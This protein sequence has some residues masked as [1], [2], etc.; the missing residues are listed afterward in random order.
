M[1]FLSDP[2]LGQEQIIS[3]LATGATTDELAGNSQALAGKAT[4]LVL[5]DLYRRT[6]KKHESVNAEPKET[7]ADKV[8]LDVGATDP[9]T[10]KQEVSAGFKITDTVQFVAD[11]GIEGDLRGA[12]K[13]PHSFPVMMLAR[14]FNAFVDALRRSRLPIAV[15]V[16]MR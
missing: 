15:V 3:L 7:L 6:F 5:Q 13:V 2:P 11:L 14:S 10:G 12:A 9:A 16:S 4:L 1:N 8:N